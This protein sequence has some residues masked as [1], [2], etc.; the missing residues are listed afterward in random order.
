MVGIFKTPMFFLSFSLSL[1]LYLFVTLLLYGWRGEYLVEVDSGFFDKY[2]YCYYFYYY[3]YYYYY[4][5]Y[6]SSYLG[7]FTWI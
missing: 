5:Y 7:S 3:Y 2:Y 4:F 1:F 6:Y